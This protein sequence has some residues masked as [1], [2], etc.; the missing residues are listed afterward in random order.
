MAGRSKNAHWKLYELK[1]QMRAAIAQFA[2]LGGAA[3]FY[4]LGSRR[5]VTRRGT[6]GSRNPVGISSKGE[7][8]RLPDPAPLRS[9]AALSDPNS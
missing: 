4:R 7:S 3:G 8:Y 9:T 2:G 5:S 1:S 6:G